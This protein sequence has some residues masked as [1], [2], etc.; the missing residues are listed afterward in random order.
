MPRPRKVKPSEKLEKEQQIADQNM[1][2]VENF[3]YKGVTRKN[4]PHAGL[5]RYDVK[6]EA[7]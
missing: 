4:I 5:A 1:R 2:E 6:E 3:T 7:R